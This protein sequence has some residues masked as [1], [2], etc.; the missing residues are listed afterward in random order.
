MLSLDVIPLLSDLTHHPPT[1]AEAFY[2]TELRELMAL[3]E[4]KSEPRLPCSIVTHPGSSRAQNASTVA[5]RLRSG[6]AFR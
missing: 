6:R 4:N 5:R 2:K 1:M 3:P